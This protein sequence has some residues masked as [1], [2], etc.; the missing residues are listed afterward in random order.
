[1][2]R[3][4][5]QD[6]IPNPHGGPPWCLQTELSEAEAE[7]AARDLGLAYGWAFSNTE[8]GR[9]AAIKEWLISTGG[10]RREG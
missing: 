6:P 5:I 3:Y 7:R 2:A 8:N 9:N 4:I 10:W 1:M